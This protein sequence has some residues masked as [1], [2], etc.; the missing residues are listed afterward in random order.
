MSNPSTDKEPVSSLS[1]PQQPHW[2]QPSH[3][4]IQKVIHTS[5]ETGFGT[6]SY[7][8]ITIPPGG[9]YTTLHFPPCKLLKDDEASYA[10]VQVGENQHVDLGCDFLYTEH[11][12]DPSLVFP[13]NPSR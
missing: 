11:S 4:E 9:L 6:K 8:T 10:T 2:K 3:P 7:S 13:S 1:T 5:S 12:C